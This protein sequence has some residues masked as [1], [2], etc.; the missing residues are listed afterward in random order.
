VCALTVNAVAGVNSQPSQVERCAPLATQMEYAILYTFSTIPQALGGAFALLSAFVLFRFQSLNSAM[1]ADSHGLR[2]ALHDV[3]Q[4]NNLDWLIS[5]SD[6]A[7]VHQFVDSVIK[8][9]ERDEEG[10]RA[11][12]EPSKPLLARLGDSLKLHRDLSRLFLRSAIA[13]GVMMIGSVAVLPFAH[14]IYCWCVVAWTVMMLGVI[15]FAVTLYLYWD[16][17]RSALGMR[18]NKKERAEISQ[19]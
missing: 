9:R 16:L 7:A 10:A 8:G 12:V 3:K 18:I 2:R 19:P 6:F 13:T 4:T 5:Q 15:G 11:I 14:V 1:L 17:I